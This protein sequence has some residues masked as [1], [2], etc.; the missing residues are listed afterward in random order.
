MS[1]FILIFIFLSTAFINAQEKENQKNEKKGKYLYRLE[2]ASWY[3][4]DD[5]LVRFPELKDSIGG[6]LSYY[7]YQEHPKTIFYSKTTDK[8][9]VRYEFDSIPNT[10]PKSYETENLIL[11]PL[12]KKL[13]NI[14]KKAKEILYSNE[15]A[16]FSFYKNTNFN[17]I[18][19]EYE[20]Q[21]E[22]IFLTATNESNTLYLGNDYC[23]KFNS[24]GDLI[25]KEKLHNSL[26]KIPFKSENKE[27]PIKATMHSH[28]LNDLF[29]YTDICSLL[30]YKEYVEWNTHYIIGKKYVSIFDLKKEILITIKLKAWKKMNK[31]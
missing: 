22:V 31:N 1:K 30:M 3:G 20:G 23:L 19:I 24:N 6:Y 7:D 2:K 11:T 14:R 5:F 4:T 8:V 25:D 9:F 28:V 17:L 16:F 12:E 29:T 13:I 26:I 15:N 10:F 27:N 21:L 18:P